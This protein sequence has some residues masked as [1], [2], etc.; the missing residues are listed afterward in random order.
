M[1]VDSLTVLELWEHQQGHV[2]LHVLKEMNQIWCFPALREENAQVNHAEQSRFKALN[3]QRF[4]KGLKK[5]NWDLVVALQPQFNLLAGFTDFRERMWPSLCFLSGILCTMG[6]L[7]ISLLKI[8]RH[9]LGK[10]LR[11]KGTDQL[12]KML[13]ILALE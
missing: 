13:G 10:S 9:T 11:Q 4:V 6:G 3:F 7:N 12:A 5:K 8:L 1:E 2:H